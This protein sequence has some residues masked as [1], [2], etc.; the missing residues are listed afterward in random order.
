M[1]EETRFEIELTTP[2]IEDMCIFDNEEDKYLES[3]YEVLGLLNQMDEEIR[4]LE[5]SDLMGWEKLE[6]M[7]N[8]YS[9]DIHS[10]VMYI[11]RLE[12]KVDYFK[13]MNSEK[14]KEIKEQQSSIEQLQEENKELKQKLENLDLNMKNDTVKMI[15]GKIFIRV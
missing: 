10:K 9:K 3:M 13:K 5:V 14:K 8:K 4:E 11:K 7:E 15:D 1:D 6:R 12:Y 2:Y